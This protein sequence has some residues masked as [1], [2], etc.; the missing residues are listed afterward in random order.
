MADKGPKLG[1]SDSRAEST[2]ITK[3]N[4]SAVKKSLYLTVALV[5]GG[6]GTSAWAVADW[7]QNLQADCSGT[8]TSKAC[9]GIPAVTVSGWSTGTGT[10]SAPSTGTTFAAATVVNYGSTAG[11]GML[12][13]NDVDTNGPHAM[14]NV[15]GIDA[16]LLNFSAGGPVNL[17]SVTIGWNGTDNGGLYTDS[18]LSL[19]AWTGGGVGPTMAGSSEQL[20]SNG[21][22]LIGNYSDVGSLTNPTN[23]AS[24]TSGVFSSYW[25]IS[26][27]SS[28][29]GA[30]NSSAIGSLTSYNDSFKVLSIAGNTCTGT[31]SGAKC[32]TNQTP[33]PGSLALL[34]AGVL[35]YLATRRRKSV[36]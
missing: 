19:L 12:S 20:L 7:T 34:G 9:G 33:E 4:T 32:N 5:L 29:Y 25:L 27:Y 13:A 22:T 8:F 3:M 21:W 1:Q 31:V 11:L 24:N 10:T 16:M 36:G 6:L 15:D 30:T 2:E 35:G 17:S 18:D 28:A 14:D 23:T 26:A